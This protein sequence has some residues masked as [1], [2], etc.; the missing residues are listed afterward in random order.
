MSLRFHTP[1]KSL[2]L[3][4][5][6]AIG[7]VSH[8]LPTLR[9]LQKAWPATRITWIIGKTELALV[10]DIPDVEFIVFDKTKGWQAYR[11]LRRALKGRTFDLLLHMQISLRASLASLAVKAPIRLGFDRKRA[12][13]L[14]WLFSTHK[15]A[16]VPRQHVLD[17]FL[18]FPRALGLDVANVEWDIPIPDAARSKVREL[19]PRD[20]PLIAI[21]PCSSVRI[22]NYRNWNVEAYAKI[23]DY[24]AEKFGM[25]TVLTGGP[26]AMEIDYAAAIEKKATTKPLNLVGKTSLKELLAVLECAAVV[27]APDTG[28]AHL[29]NAVGT[30]VIGLYATSNPERTGPYLNRELTVNR[31][32]EALL[33]EK[34]KTVDE[35]R[36]GQR[37]RNPGAMELIEVSDVLERLGA[38]ASRDKDG[39]PV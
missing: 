38:L 8:V 32:P 23:I 24:A 30:P 7:D 18:E 39:P 1:P 31:Y 13:N 11:E 5:L 26:S 10:R 15:I 22:R 29:A 3:L 12:R 6:S 27:V 2:C 21:N 34:G 20:Q 17:S 4:R 25:V 37:V 36:W 19:L 33:E 35:V 28:P 9:V 14:Q 16:A